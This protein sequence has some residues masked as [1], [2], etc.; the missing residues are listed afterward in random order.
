VHILALVS[1][2]TNNPAALPILD[3]SLLAGLDWRAKQNKNKHDP[4]NPISNAK[5]VQSCALGSPEIIDPAALPILTWSLLAGF[6]WRA[7]QKTNTRQC[8]KSAQF[9]SCQP[10]NH[11]SCS[12]TNPRMKPSCRPQLESKLHRAGPNQWQIRMKTSCLCR[13]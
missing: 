6:D 5:R 1:P 7:K 10:R 12:F 3:W 13:R 4:L 9:S 2:E 11:Q 8:Q